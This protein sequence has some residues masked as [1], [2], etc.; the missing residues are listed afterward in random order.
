MRKSWIAAGAAALML[1]LAACGGG[2][3]ETDGTATG[4]ST[5]TSDVAEGGD[6]VLGSIQYP[7]S[8][9]VEGFSIA[10]LTVF[11]GAVYDTLIRQ[12]GEGNLIPGLA[13]E[14][15]YDDARTTLTLTLRDGVTFTDGTPFNADAVV[16]NMEAFKASATADLSTAQYI[17]TVAAVDDTT[18]E[19]S[20]SAPDPMLTTWLSNS[21]GYM[22]SP[23]SIGAADAA[24]NPVGT[25]PYTLDQANTVVGS[26]YAFTRN[27][28]YWD[29]SYHV[30]DSLTINYYETPT[31]LLNALQGNQV[32][33][34]SFSDVSSITQVEGAGYTVNSM[35]LDWSGLI[36]FDR[37]GVVD[38]PLG[39]VEVRQA[40]NYAID[41]ETML[42]VIQL[43]YGTVTSSVFGEAT[44]GYL[45]ELDSYYEYNPDMARDLLA[46]AGYADGFALTMPSTSLIPQALLT[47]IQQQLAD[48][49][50]TVNYQDTGANF[51]TDLL[52]GK[53][54]STWMQ[55][56]SANDWQFV[57]LALAPESIFNVF[58]NETPEATALIDTMQT[59]TEEEA[60][61]AAQD[62]NRY[63][64]ENAWF[65]PFYRIDTFYLSDDE[66]SVTMAA[67]NVVPYL[68]MIQPAN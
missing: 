61:V 3:S 65:A 18:V 12:D 67:D 31:A 16:A 39:S 66:V 53:F 48:V 25:G 10:H 20:L 58:D 64:T 60:A 5:G 6:L 46:D 42:E 14:W 68:Y 28:D 38:E 45:P 34:S 9:D 47:T 1:G 43:G 35:Q 26:K 2:S 41:R 33:A 22:A 17:D 44:D 8:W 57:Q 29:D 4:G 23:A 63:V 50:I 36:L 30:Y 37:D 32:D 51:I 27:P 11:F 24:T 19:F 55:L 52:G 54:T 56:A 62:L 49:G 59:G 40:I 15:S 13:T 7:T 21:L